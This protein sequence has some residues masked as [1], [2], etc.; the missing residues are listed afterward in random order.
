LG[1][2][3]DGTRS[4]GK[5]EHLLKGVERNE[6]LKNKHSIAIGR[7]RRRG[8]K[9][10]A[11]RRVR[12]GHSNRNWDAMKGGKLKRELGCSRRSNEQKPR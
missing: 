6:R 11:H 9:A 2:Y 4:W 10:P 8:K 3:L 7:C 1:S 5:G 12:E